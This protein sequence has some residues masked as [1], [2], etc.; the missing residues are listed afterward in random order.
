LVVER[1]DNDHTPEKIAVTKPWRRPRPTQGCGASNEE[2]EE[3]SCRMHF[4]C[5]KC[6]HNFCRRDS[7][8]NVLLNLSEDVRIILNRQRDLIDL[9]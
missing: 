6:I 7:S 4:E 1:G 8:E 9:V 2:E 3:E 5:D